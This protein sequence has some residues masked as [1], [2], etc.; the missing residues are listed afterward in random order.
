[1]GARVQE[2]AAEAG[3]NPALIHYYF[4]SKEGLAAA[5][6]R[7]AAGRL[8]PAVAELVVADVPLEEK[9]ERFI[10]LYIDGVRGSPF[11]PGYI[12]SELHHH[13]ERQETLRAIAKLAP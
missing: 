5:V 7:E 8:V 10:H 12:V 6:F 3:V 9:I 2:I 1:A 11:L 13:A 4:R